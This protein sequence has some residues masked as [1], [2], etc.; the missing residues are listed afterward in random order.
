MLALV[1]LWPGGFGGEARVVAIGTATALWIFSK[2]ERGAAPSTAMRALGWIG[3]FSYSLYLIHL[4]VLSPFTN[5]VQ[6]FVHP[7]RLSFCATWLAAVLLSGAAGWALYRWVE[8]PLERWRKSRWS[9][10]PVPN[11]SSA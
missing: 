8:A 5:L 1:A 3:A 11:P 6:R 7:D 4:A 10:R 9:A 2:R